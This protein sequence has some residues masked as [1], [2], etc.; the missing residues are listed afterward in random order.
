MHASMMKIYNY[1]VFFCCECLQNCL[2]R[3]VFM[4]V[5]CIFDEDFD[6]LSFVYRQRQLHFPFASMIFNKTRRTNGKSTTSMV[7]IILTLFRSKVSIK[8][9]FDQQGFTDFAI[10]R[11]TCSCGMQPNPF[12]HFV[13]SK[14]RNLFT[15]VSLKIGYM[16]RAG[17]N[18]AMK[19]HAKITI[20]RSS[21]K[22]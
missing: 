22:Y 8:I 4:T 19:I 3:I 17:L 13:S 2:Y 16:V 10:N 5:N 18:V 11:S 12:V 6:K 15:S 9:Y 14:T 21:F 1:N 7:D 20:E